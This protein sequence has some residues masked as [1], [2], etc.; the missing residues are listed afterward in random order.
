[1]NPWKILIIRRSQTLDVRQE[2]VDTRNVKEG[3]GHIPFSLT[4]I[5]EQTIDP[6]R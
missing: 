1:M 3:L 4:I 2:F 5:F 6:Q